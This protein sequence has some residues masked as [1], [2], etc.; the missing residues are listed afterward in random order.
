[1]TWRI[2]VGFV[3]D[4]HYLS[5]RGITKELEKEPQI[6]ISSFAPASFIE[7]GISD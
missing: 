7:D 6:Y 3:N 1:M 4:V 2:P 5:D